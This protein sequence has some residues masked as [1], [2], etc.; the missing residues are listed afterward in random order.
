[1]KRTLD[2]DTGTA[3]AR[4]LVAASARVRY[5][6]V[7]T[8]SKLDKAALTPHAGAIVNMLT[9]YDDWVRRMALVALGKLDKVALTP[10]AGA[11]VNMLTDSNDWVSRAASMA[12]CY[13]EPAAL[14]LHMGTIAGMLTDSDA[15][16]RRGA[17]RV[18]AS[19]TKSV[20]P[21]EVLALAIHAT[22]TMLTDA[23]TLC[24]R[25]WAISTLHNGVGCA[26]GSTV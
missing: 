4:A 9:D 1:M 10:H 3:L 12:L 26:H 15:N 13:L 5:A 20:R 14:A 11:I 21:P 18:L 22:T 2:H 8:I 16:V 25:S 17:L 6:A 19:I 24:L 7:V 23:E